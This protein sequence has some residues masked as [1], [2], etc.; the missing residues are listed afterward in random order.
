MKLFS[1]YKID[2]SGKS[3]GEVRTLCPECSPR[4]K[5]ASAKCLAVNTDKGTWICHHCDWR[6]GLQS[7]QE[8]PGRKIIQRPAWRTTPTPTALLLEWFAGRGIS[9]ATV[10]REGIALL[11]H[12]LAQAEDWVPCIAFPYRKGG[13]VVNIKYR[14]LREKVFQQVSGAEKILYRQDH[15]TQDCVVIVEGEMDALSIVQAGINSVVSVPDGAP[16]VTAKNYAS[17]FTYLDQDP[18]PFERVEKIVLAVDA[19]APGQ[20][21]QRELSRR[22]GMDRC[23]FV[24]WPDSCKDANDVLCQYG[25]DALRFL[26]EQ[27]QPFPV[28]DVVEVQDVAESVR[29]RY[30]HGVARGLSTGWGNVDA[31]YTIESGQLTVITGIPGHGKSEWLDALMLNLMH[32]HGWRF[33]VCSPE[34]APVEQ[35]IEKLMEKV[36]GAPFRVGPSDR[37]TPMELSDGLIWLQDYVRFV[38]PEDA[39]TIYGLLDRATSLVRRFGI[40]GL[41]IDPFNEFDHTRPRGQTETEYI[42]S[43]LSALT[44]WARKWQV[45]VWLVAHPQKLYRRDDGTYPVPTPWD[46][47][48]SAN[49]RNKAA[50]CLTVWRDEDNTDLP[51]RVYVQK[52]RYKHIGMVGMVELTWDRRTGRYSEPVEAEA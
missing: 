35:H 32:L 30:F 19:D 37:M 34:N 24:T 2:L 49:F 46:I 4:R 41:I 47:N 33:A 31:H 3:G 10:Q 25:A 52:I 1:D 26:I 36:V 18:E 42:G 29:S 43:M 21:L 5:N 13:E 44:R 20:L 38:M 12:Y 50:N 7:G 6:G 27:A 23:Y 48:G 39:L 51:V 14:G 16:A 22:L 11:D 17:K 40:R 45:H 28:Q 8:Q 15:I 9:E